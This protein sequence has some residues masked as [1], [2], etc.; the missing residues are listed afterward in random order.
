MKEIKKRLKEI[1]DKIDFYNN[2]K[3]KYNTFNDFFYNKRIMLSNNIIELINER[4]GINLTLREL[5]INIR[6]V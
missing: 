1:E 6:K 4:R 2:N 3:K 5:K